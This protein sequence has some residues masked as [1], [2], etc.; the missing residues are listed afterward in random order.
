MTDGSRAFRPESHRSPRPV[1]SAVFATSMTQG[2][3]TCMPPRRVRPLSA[4][5]SPSG[6]CRTRSREPRST[7]LVREHAES[8]ARKSQLIVAFRT[9]PRSPTR[10]P[11]TRPM[12]RKVVDAA[13]HG[14]WSHGSSSLPRLQTSPTRAMNRALLSRGR[15]IHG[16]V[17]INYGARGDAF[18]RL[19]VQAGP[20]GGEAATRHRLRLRASGSRF[21][22]RVRSL[23]PGASS[24]RLQRPTLLSRRPASWSSSARTL[25]C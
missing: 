10:W 24:R 13:A 22:H 23:V 4:K 14:H 2:P 6:R 15:C 7:R 19:R 3:R 25:W 9:A 18:V 11:D 17:P 20:R 21:R 16:H 5:R 1:S 12:S 8:L